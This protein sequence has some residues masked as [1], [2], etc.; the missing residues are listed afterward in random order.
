MHVIG[1]INIFKCIYILFIILIYECIYFLP[2]KLSVVPLTRHFQ[3]FTFKGHPTR[4]TAI[5]MEITFLQVYNL[6]PWRAWRP[7]AW[8][9]TR[10]A[11]GA[12]LNH[13]LLWPSWWSNSK[14]HICYY[15]IHYSHSVPNCSACIQSFSVLMNSDC[16]AI[17][18]CVFSKQEQIIICT[19][20][21]FHPRSFHYIKSACS[22]LQWGL[23]S[24][25][26]VF[27][28]LCIAVLYR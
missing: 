18:A 25:I 11:H 1:V 4:A 28:T 8:Y 27:N 6:I 15:D 9:L 7:W 10:V 17:S 16:L 20:N 5:E 26:F 22:S 3:S 24:F 23:G 14:L 12:S 13:Y 2:Q 19:S 21:E